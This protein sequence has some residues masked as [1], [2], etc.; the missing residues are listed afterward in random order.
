MI[1]GMA[2][3]LMAGIT[4]GLNPAWA[5]GRA[6]VSLFAWPGFGLMAGPDAALRKDLAGTGLH[7]DVVGL[8]WK[9]PEQWLQEF[10][11]EYQNDEGESLCVSEFPSYISGFTTVDVR[12]VV[13]LGAVSLRAGVSNQV[14]R[15]IPDQVGEFLV[16]TCH[17]SL[18]GPT[19]TLASAPSI[20]LFFNAGPMEISTDLLVRVGVWADDPYKWGE[21]P[22]DEQW[23]RKGTDFSPLTVEVPVRFAAEL[24]PVY[25]R[26][27]LMAGVAFPTK[28]RKLM[29]EESPSSFSE[30]PGLEFA[31]E[32]SVAVGITF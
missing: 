28:N 24:G 7:V 16:E 23:V 30:E 3:L 9:G 29:Y 21:E 1:A 26:A 31:K 27:G 15:G 8:Y 12:G 6:G 22:N 10:L 20:G 2:L 32:A 5:G 18:E 19:I 4:G 25:V 13:G 11:T 14:K 17:V